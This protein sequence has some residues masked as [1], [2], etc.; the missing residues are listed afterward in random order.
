[1]VIRV[2]L[3]YQFELEMPSLSANLTSVAVVIDILGKEYRCAVAWPERLELLQYAQEFGSNLGEVQH[4]VNIDHRGL[5]LRNDSSR[6]EQL[7]PL[8]ESRK[9]LLFQCETGCIEV[10]SE[11]LQQV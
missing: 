5:H 10:T 2:R 3:L 6:D 9:V 8:A 11:I 1:M 7:Y 4:R